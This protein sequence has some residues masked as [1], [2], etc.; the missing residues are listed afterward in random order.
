MPSRYRGHVRN[1]PAR[2]KCL[3]QNLWNVDSV[4]TAFFERLSFVSHRTDGGRISLR[5]SEVPRNSGSTYSSRP[6]YRACERRRRKP[7]FKSTS[8]VSE[9]SYSLPS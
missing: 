6:P 2:G 3:Q 9:L 4:Q 5:K 8:P 7:A 1:S